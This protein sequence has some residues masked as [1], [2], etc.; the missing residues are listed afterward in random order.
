MPTNGE[1]EAP[2]QDKKKKASNGT[3]RLKLNSKL[4]IV[5]DVVQLM[6]E[7]QISE[8]SF[9]EKGIKIHLRK[10]PGV[11]FGSFVPAMTGPSASGA[12]SAPPPSTVSAASPEPA[13]KA[14]KQPSLNAPMVGTF[15]RAAAPDA[16]P[17]VEEGAQIEV[18][19]VYCIIEAMKLMNE[20][21]SE[22]SGRVVRILVQNGQA[23]EFNQPLVVIDPS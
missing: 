2:K 6:E 10:G 19:Q 3:K 15:Y 4:D 8:L 18:G 5:Q 1:K 20:V 12:V 14:E 23:V 13:S 17:F 9:E 7:A 22:V 11:P 16:K 21:K